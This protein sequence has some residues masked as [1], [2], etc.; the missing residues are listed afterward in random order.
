M[1]FMPN[2]GSVTSHLATLPR[3][4]SCHL[5]ISMNP[6]VSSVMAMYSSL[7]GHGAMAFEWPPLDEVGFMNNCLSMLPFSAKLK[8]LM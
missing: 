6:T 7:H 2:P 4:P 3:N 5:Y 8:A 1:A